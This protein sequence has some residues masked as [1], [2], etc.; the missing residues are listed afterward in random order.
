MKTVVGISLGAGDQDFEFRA[1]FLGHRFRILRVGTNGST[2][3]A[4]KLLKHWEHHADAIGLGVVK[5]SYAVGARRYVE[6]DSAR[7]KAAVTRVAVTTGGRLSDI[8]QEWALR[9]V[10]IKLG[11]YFNNARVLFFS[12]M[13]NYKLALA[14]AEYTQNLEFADPVLQLG[15]PKLVTSLDALELYTSGAH[16]VLDYL[17]SNLMATTPIKAWTKFV[18]RQA[19]RDATVIVAPVHELDGFGADVLRGK[20]LI[21]STVN[22]RRI[23]QF[24]KKGV[25][26]VVDGAPALFDHVL[27]PSLLD[28]MIVAAREKD[29]DD[30][31]E[32][33]Y[34]EI[35]TSLALEPRVV[36]PNGFK[37]VNRFASSS[38]R[39]RR[40]I[41]RTSSRSSCSRR[42]RRQC[43]W[44]RWKR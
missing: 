16:Y 42:S 10:Q 43:S 34:L 1:R 21:T 29:P 5:D 35:I 15:V 9:H 12:G 37:R 18:L 31:L 32:D 20:T 39:W 23:A 3:Q 11:D 19:M 28:A 6:R 13:T 8:L 33:D 26:M 14:M 25:H 2:T 40:S 27:S 7:L 36:Y 24:R 44:T 38:T 22:D 4:L 41:S 17:P 30:I